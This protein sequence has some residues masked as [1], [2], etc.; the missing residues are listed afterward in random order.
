MFLNLGFKNLSTDY[1]AVVD[2]GSGSV[3]VAIIEINHSK[4][5]PKI[6]WSHRE[7]M[8]V[9]GSNT[10]VEQ[11][12]NSAILNA[13]LV[14]GNDGV[15]YLN[16]HDGGKISNIQ[17]SFS[18]PWSYTI[19]RT[20]HMQADKAFRVDRE[21]LNELVEKASDQAKSHIT[22]NLLSGKLA[23]ET[24]AN[25]TVSIT[26]NG[27]Q[28]SE[29]Y[30]DNI[31]KLSVSQLI[32]MVSKDLYDHILLNSEKILPNAEVHIN[33]FMYFYYR[34]LQRLAPKTAEA[35]LIDITAESTELGIIRNGVLE[36]STNI[37]YGLYTLAREISKTCNLPPEAA[38]S[39]I[40]DNG[41]QAKI[42][43]DTEKQA[44]ID[45]AIDAYEKELVDLFIRTG[46]SLSLPKTIFMHT[47]HRYEN[48]FSER[49]RNAAHLSTKTDHSVHLVTSKFFTPETDTDSALLLSAYVLRH[50]L[51]DAKYIDF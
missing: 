28:V 18:A 5:Y 14:L 12:L 7:R 46:D 8:A 3:G 41:V 37:N 50:E 27:Y 29:P 17:V 10:S 16:E 15:R 2:V 43:L 1:G 11:R 45:N 34:S 49:I 38:L 36:S 19:S 42:G 9:G 6:V 22:E 44:Y 4:S 31:N 30:H 48:F 47:D 39:C 25:K 13:F 51:S 23:L 33:T 24:V 20:I 21:L 40:K 35:C 26:E 32:A